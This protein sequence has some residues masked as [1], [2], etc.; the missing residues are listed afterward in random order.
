MPTT[1][2]LLE[3]VRR[4]EISLSVYDL[5]AKVT[6]QALLEL[7]RPIL[8]SAGLVRT[9]Y[10]QFEWLLR[11]LGRVLRSYRGWDLAFELELLLRKWNRYGLDTRVMQRLVRESFRR[12]A[13]REEDDHAGQEETDTG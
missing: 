7:G 8:D 1:R 3:K 5:D 11:E 13:I 9:V 4:D 6:E 10:L 2:R 12:L